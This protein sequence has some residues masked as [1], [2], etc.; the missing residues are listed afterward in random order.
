MR[1]EHLRV[2]LSAWIDGELSAHD[3]AR[4]AEHLR[5]CRE[6]SDHVGG[7]QD[8]SSLVRALPAPR[9]PASITQVAMRHVSAMTR[10]SASPRPRWLFSFAWPVPALS[11]GLVGLAAAIALALFVGWPEQAKAPAEN[12][13]SLHSGQSSAANSLPNGAGY[14]LSSA[15]DSVTGSIAITRGYDFRG[16]QSRRDIGTFNARERYAWDHGVWHHEQRFGRDGWWW[17]VEG[18]WYWYEKS[19][20]GPPAI[21]SDVRFPADSGAIGSMRQPPANAAG[22]PQ[23]R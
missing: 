8:T 23:P 7:L 15:P 13:D 14:H 17:D 1:C 22:P 4:I 16:G 19:E 12:S 3:R 10:Q 2:E 20:S 21:V 5:T 11:V 18:A 9:A 6:C